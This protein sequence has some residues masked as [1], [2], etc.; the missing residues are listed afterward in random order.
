MRITELIWAARLHEKCSVAVFECSIAMMH[1]A[2]TTSETQLLWRCSSETGGEATIY[3]RAGQ[4]RSFTA[5]CSIC[6][7]EPAHRFCGSVRELMDSLSLIVRSAA[8]DTA[9]P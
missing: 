2:F 8:R 9:C 7:N 3:L 6:G 5:L 1:C 4:N